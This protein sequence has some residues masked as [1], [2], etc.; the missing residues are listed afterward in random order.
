[1]I[2]GSSEDIRLESLF[3]LTGEMYYANKNRCP[4]LLRKRRLRTVQER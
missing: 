2:G 3:E 4:P 1:M